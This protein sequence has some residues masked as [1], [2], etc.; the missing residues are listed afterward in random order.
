MAE[1]L[2]SPAA[3]QDMETIFDYTVEQFTIIRILHERMN[4]T[5]HL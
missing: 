2:L 3:E 5:L 4:P 1:Y